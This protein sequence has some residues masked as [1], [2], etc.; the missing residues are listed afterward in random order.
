MSYVVRK[1]TVKQTNKRRSNITP[2]IHVEE[3]KTLKSVR[4]WP[5]S[6]S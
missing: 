1:Q 5:Y 3:V 2:T 6:G 4:Y